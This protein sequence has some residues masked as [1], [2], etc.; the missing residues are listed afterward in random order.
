MET[1][2]IHSRKLDNLFAFRHTVN[3]RSAQW[4]VRDKT[5]SYIQYISGVD[6]NRSLYLIHRIS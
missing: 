1:T 3:Y 2:E 6:E 5:D 4:K